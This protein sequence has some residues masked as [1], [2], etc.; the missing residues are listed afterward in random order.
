MFLLGGTEEYGSMV[1]SVM[2]QYANSLFI[3]VG[4]SMGGNII[5]KFLGEHPETQKRFIGAVACCQAYDVNEYE[6][7]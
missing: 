2:K 6:L 1:E 5:T 3:A 7:G 4:F